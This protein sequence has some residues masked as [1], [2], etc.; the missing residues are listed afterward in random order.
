MAWGVN[1]TNTIKCELMADYIKT[2]EYSEIGRHREGK[3]NSPRLD[4]KPD[5]CF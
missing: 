2:H 1:A 3:R 4:S 5:S